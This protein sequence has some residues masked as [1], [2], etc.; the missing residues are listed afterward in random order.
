MGEHSEE[1]GQEWS[2]P[3]LISSLE[4]ER[5]YFRYLG[6]LGYVHNINLLAKK[7]GKE[8]A[9]SIALIQLGKYSDLNNYGTKEK[10]VVVDSTQHVG[11]VMNFVVSSGCL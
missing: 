10:S 1:A 3:N 11:N 2:H 9:A 5:S 7:R 4:F 6:L 8:E